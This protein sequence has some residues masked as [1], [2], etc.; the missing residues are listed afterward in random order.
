MTNLDFPIIGTK[1]D[2]VTQDFDLADPEVRQTYFEAKVGSELDTIKDFLEKNQF[3]AYFIGKKN[4]GKGTYSKMLT[5]TLK[6][7]KIVHLSVG[8][9][10]R[11]VS[12]NWAEYE[13]GPEYPKL[14]ALYRGALDFEKA[15]EYLTSRS[16]SSLLPSDFVL[17]LLRVRFESLEGKSVFLDGF[18]REKDQVGY[19]LYLKEILGR[20]QNKDM[21]ILIDIPDSVINERIKYRRICPI[22]NTP[23]NLKV[24]ATQ[25]V[26]YDKETEEFF[27]MCDTPSCNKERMVAKEGD[28][29]GIEPIRERLNKDQSIIEEAYGLYGIDKILLRNSIPVDQAKELFDPYEITPG[30]DY[31]R[32]AGSDK[33]KVVE[34][35]WVIQDNQGVDSNSLLPMPV[36]V[37]L[38]K[39][40]S[41]ILSK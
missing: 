32:V 19:T 12:G 20:A 14:K 9:L 25:D 2:G 39:Q 16:T 41:K 29:L 18:P 31:E 35:P 36:V 30:Y 6:T 15:V 8:D 28:S 38:I 37:G 10:V 4:S 13:K 1:T 11:E 26:G 17:A 5:E 22:C 21:V 3:I 27:L 34:S 24:L 33:V 7:D 23:R 40:L